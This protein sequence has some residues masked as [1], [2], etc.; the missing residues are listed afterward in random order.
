MNN[1]YDE[2]ANRRLTSFMY[3]AFASGPAGREM[4]SIMQSYGISTDHVSCLSFLG[5]EVRKYSDGTR[6]PYHPLG[7][8]RLAS[9]KGEHGDQ[10]C[11]HTDTSIVVD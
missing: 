6:T 10:L 8:A 9:I 11:V 1:S 2:G 4:T 3:L 5:C 7:A